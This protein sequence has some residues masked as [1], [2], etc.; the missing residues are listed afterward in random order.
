MDRFAHRPALSRRSS[1]RPTYGGRRIR[2]PRSQRAALLWVAMV[3]AASPSTALAFETTQARQISSDGQTMTI[4]FTNLPVSATD[5]QVTVDLLG[6]YEGAGEYADVTIDGVAPLG[7]NVN[8]SGAQCNSNVLGANASNRATLAVDRT[9]VDDSAL[10]VVIANSPNVSGTRCDNTIGSDLVYVTLQ[11]STLPDLTHRGFTVPVGQGDIIV[12]QPFDAQV[13]IYNFGESA[14]TAPYRNVLYYCPA[15]NP[16]G[17]I[18]LDSFNASPGTLA[19]HTRTPLLPSSTPLGP[20]YIRL[21]IDADDTVAETNENNN[22]AYAPI[23]VV[24]PTTPD[25][26]VLTATVPVGGTSVPR[27]GRVHLELSIINQGI[28]FSG[29]TTFLLWHCRERN[30]RN[31]TSGGGFRF[32]NGFSQGEVRSAT[33]PFITGRSVSPPP[34]GDFLRIQLDSNDLLA[35]GATGEANNDSYHPFIYTDPSQ[36]DLYASTSSA[37]SGTGYVASGGQVSINYTIGNQGSPL[38]SPFTVAID[39]CPSAEVTGCMPGTTRSVLDQFTTIRRR[40]YTDTFTLPSGLTAEHAY[41]RI[42]VDSAATITEE[43]ETNNDHYHRISVRPPELFASTSTIPSTPRTLAPGE[44]ITFAYRLE[45]GATAG[46]VTEPFFVRHYYCEAENTSGCT[47]ISDDIMVNDDFATGQAREYTRTY[48]LPTHATVGTRYLRTFVDSMGNQIAESD[49]TNN[50]LYQAITIA[51]P[52]GIAGASCDVC[53][54]DYYGF[55]ECNYCLSSTTCNNNGACDSVGGCA[56]DAGFAGDACQYSD[57]TTCSRGGVAQDDGSCDCNPGFAG[58]ACQYSDAA[59]CNGNGIAQDDGACFCAPGAAGP[60]CEF[61][62]QAHCSGHGSAQATGNCLCAATY[63]GPACQYSDK[64]TCNGG[65]AV[66]D[67]GGCTCAPEFAGEAC[68][69]SDT[70]TCSSHGRAQADGT[71]VCEQGYLGQACQNS[72]GE[73]CEGQGAVGP[74]GSCTCDDGFTGDGCEQPLPASCRCIGRS[75]TPR[76]PRGLALILVLLWVGRRRRAS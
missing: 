58:S 52:A 15:R 10:T 14:P 13:R 45:N 44:T 24:A 60:A 76:W 69:Y 74:D 66:Q 57:L 42:S 39:Y 5:V 33:T 68:Q 25:L 54:T 11:Y 41:V 55:P 46:A 7:S 37:A 49:E 12:G 51:C 21:V 16:T 23:T 71:C 28:S 43:D 38:S 50:D 30:P 9:L 26:R 17:C 36:P 40:S 31:C 20:A 18:A 29:S 47:P 62:D 3:I 59:T 72:G 2:D 35:E 67:D 75:A 22:N 64:E 34:S 1:L 8:P 53:D 4:N 27:G 61:S 56:C 48:V 19:D 6:D 63:A 32:L 65:G 70:E 73:T